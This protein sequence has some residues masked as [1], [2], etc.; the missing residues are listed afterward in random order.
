MVLETPSIILNMHPALSVVSKSILCLKWW[1]KLWCNAA[2]NTFYT[3]YFLLLPFGLN[4]IPY[5][6]HNF[7]RISRI[8]ILCLLYWSCNKKSSPSGMQ[9]PI[10]Y[11]FVTWNGCRWIGIV[12]MEQ[13]VEIALPFR[14]ELLSIS[15]YP[16]NYTTKLIKLSILNEFSRNIRYYNNIILCCCWAML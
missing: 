10:Y 5:E 4:R 15:F 13:V 9:Q 11:W 12:V 16:S 1:E 3:N 7:R 6:A 8:T 14:V 2:H